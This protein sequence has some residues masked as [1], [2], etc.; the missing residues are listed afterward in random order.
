MVRGTGRSRLLVTDEV[1]YRR[2][3]AEGMQSMTVQ[4]RGAGT[5]G[6]YTWGEHSIKNRIAEPLH[7]THETNVTMCVNLD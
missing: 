7:H 6:S 3:R 4:W 1:T 5:G 2:G